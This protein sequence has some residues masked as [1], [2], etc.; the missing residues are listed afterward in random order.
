MPV[1][2]GIHGSNDATCLPS[3]LCLHKW[4]NGGRMMLTFYWRCF[5]INTIELY[6]LHCEDF[7][8]Q[9]ALHKSDRILVQEDKKGEEGCTEAFSWRERKKCCSSC[10][11]SLFKMFKGFISNHR[12]NDSNLEFSKLQIMFYAS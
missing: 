11:S 4:E 1:L 6:Q 5:S 7:K 3:S 12:I 2:K 10:C 8:N 9:K